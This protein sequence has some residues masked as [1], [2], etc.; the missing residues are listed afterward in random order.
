M[1]LLTVRNWKILKVKCLTA[2]M[3]MITRPAT[4][5][6]TSPHPR[7]DGGFLIL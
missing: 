3:I 7:L 1:S 2:F 4:R 6:T 5:T